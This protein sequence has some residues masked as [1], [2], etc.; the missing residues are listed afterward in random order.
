MA[1]YIYTND[2]ELMHYGILGMKWGKRKSKSQQGKEPEGYSVKLQ[3]KHQKLYDKYRKAKGEEKKRLKKEL[4]SFNK[5]IGKKINEYREWEGERKLS[6]KRL[7]DSVKSVAA[8]V[9]NRRA[10]K[11]YGG[12]P[13]KKLSNYYDPNRKIK[14]AV[15]DT[16]YVASG[17]ALYKIGNM[18]ANKLY[19]NGIVDRKIASA[20]NVGS[21]FVVS[22]LTIKGATKAIRDIRN[23]SNIKKFDKFRDK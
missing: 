9:P 6:G 13:A 23:E 21:A 14:N 5:D 2:G 17:V 8:G 7:N 3:V 20:I 18:A 4:Q 15:V 16:G 11:K 19:Q 22:H 10:E 1:D 12:V